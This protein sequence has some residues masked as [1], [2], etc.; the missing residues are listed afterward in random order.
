MTG[1]IVDALLDPATPT[2]LRRRLPRVL[3]A[4]PTPRAV[5]GLVLALS[6]ARFEV[7]SQVG[8]ALVALTEK[9]PSLQVDGEAVF[10]AVRRELAADAEWEGD[11]QTRAF[12]HVFA[13]L[14]L[15]L[16]REPLKHSLWAVRGED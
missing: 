6:D 14:S 16:E 7:R 9:N 3:K 8:Q 15:V 2:V 10:A 5:E 4:S 12:E 13:L 1:Q 11:A